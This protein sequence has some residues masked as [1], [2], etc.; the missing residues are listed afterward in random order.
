[1]PILLIFSFSAVAPAWADALTACDFVSQAEVEKLLGEMVAGPTVT[2]ENLCAGLCPTINAS[3]CDFKTLATSHAKQLY[4]SVELPPY[5]F[6][7]QSER[8]ISDNN[9]RE[10]RHVSIADVSGFGKGAFRWYSADI[11]QTLFFANPGPSVRFMVQ[12]INVE[13]KA[14]LTNAI[15]V[16]TT[17]LDKYRSLPLH[18]SKR[19]SNSGPLAAP[20]DGAH[21]VEW[22]SETTIPPLRDAWCRSSGRGF[23]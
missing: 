11:E 5:E 8:N 17:A 6:S 23:R 18:R 19:H 4:L 2:D 1:M 22:T 10:M 3:R 14:A 12:E 21:E 20:T 7:M 16:V 13:P 15:A 9:A